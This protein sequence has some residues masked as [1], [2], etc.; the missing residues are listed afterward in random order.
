MQAIDKLRAQLE[1]IGAAL[2]A[3]E[4]TLTADAPAGY[5][6]RANKCSEICIPWATSR[7]RFLSAALADA[8]P[9]LRMGLVSKDN[10]LDRI[11]W[12]A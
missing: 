2:D 8:I 7:E 4:F 11:H 1:S 12:P 5:V 3:N 6:W 10:S 9:R